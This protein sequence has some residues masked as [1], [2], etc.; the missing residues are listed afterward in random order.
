MY[1]TTTTTKIF[2][3]CPLR[4]VI[5][6]PRNVLKKKY[7]ALLILIHTFPSVWPIMQIHN[8]THYG[9]YRFFKW[10]GPLGGPG[11]LPE[12]F[13]NFKVS[14]LQY[15]SISLWIITKSK[16]PHFSFPLFLQFFF[17]PSLFLLFFGR[18]GCVSPLCPPP[19][20]IRLWCQRSAMPSCSDRL[21]RGFSKIEAR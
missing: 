16:H 13:R 2:L 12:N 20:W 3:E 1:K 15:K 19:P 9:G 6:F 4:R 5:W 21:S 10:G 17:A 11:A 14:I 8:G 18:T 7:V